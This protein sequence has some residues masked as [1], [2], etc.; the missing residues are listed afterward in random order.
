MSNAKNTLAKVKETVS[1]NQY[2]LKNY[3]MDNKKLKHAM[4]GEKLQ[5]YF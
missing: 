2:D 1:Y 5:Q 4:P 3:R